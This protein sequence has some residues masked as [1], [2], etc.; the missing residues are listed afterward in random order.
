MIK[1][2]VVS[3]WSQVRLGL[4]SFAVSAAVLSGPVW[5]QSAPPESPR[6]ALVIGQVEYS[7][8]PLANYNDPD[9]ISDKLLAAGFDVEI[10]KDLEKQSIAEKLNLL[11]EKAQTFGENTTV[12]V[13]LSGRFAQIDGDNIFLP[14]GAKID[15]ATSANLNGVSIKS[16]V[17]ALKSLKVKSRVILIDGNAP[18]DTLT[19]ERTFSPGLV[20]IE[21]PEGFLISYNQRPGVPLTDVKEA[22][23]PYA[24]GLLEAIDVHTNQFSDVVQII[25]LRVTEM[26]KGAQQPFADDKLTAK[27]FSFFTPANATVS[28]DKYYVK[29]SGETD[30]TNMARDEAYKKVVSIDTI[31]SYQS[32]ITA[33][34]QDEA[35]E[36]VKFNLSARREA[37]VWAKALEL[38]TPEGYWTYIKY[39]PNG[40]NA[41]VA[42]Y[43]LDRMGEMD[44][45]PPSNFQ[46][47]VYRDIPPPVAEYE[48]LGSPSYL[49][50]RSP[51]MA[52]SLNISP[53]PVA[54]AATVAAVAAFAI[55]RN[56]GGGPRP[57]I[58]LQASRPQWAAAPA[59]NTSVT[60]APVPP[61]VSNTARPASA[62]AVNPAALAPASV[63]AARP[64]M[65]PSV[66]PVAATAAI[67]SAP[68]VSQ[69]NVTP[70]AIPTAPSSASPAGPPGV[71]ALGAP[72]AP[73]AAP[74][75][76][77]PAA[78]VTPLG[79]AP[80]A[81]RP[82]T[83][84]PVP[85]PG[86]PSP[87]A[88]PV[89]S[90]GANNAIRP[91]QSGS[92]SAGPVGGV[93][94]ISPINPA[95]P[96]GPGAGTAPITAAPQQQRIAPVGM[97]QAQPQQMQQQQ[98]FRQ[99]APA[100]QQQ[101]QRQQAA[102]AMQQRQQV[103]Q[104]PQKAA[105][106]AKVCTPP[107]RAAKQC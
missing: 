101:Q 97:P 106:A 69:S 64:A 66:A 76:G 6:I 100:M 73:T 15:T 13:Y 17:S 61:A 27:S 4:A 93:Q 7:G 48:I 95:R 38:N 85:T 74:V 46:P 57:T 45:N 53:V 32:F 96:S 40:G 80:S 68:A 58:P 98:Q 59:V 28:I 2:V 92:P 30:F 77:A 36:M 103:I 24:V 16:L 29:G 42:R 44:F 5:A 51:P 8:Y 19:K 37:E 84:G 31:Q 90:L 52:P 99:A 3:G 107:M 54:V 63:Q 56:S 70:S 35:V 22:T 23:S 82:L 14:V 41:S 18:P 75:A 71:R 34:P 102:P 62:A 9:L 87:S 21:L 49:P 12:I 25:S 26:T 86:A 89:T 88:A 11:A 20:K 78:G 55:T 65:A 81:V 79:S 50:I 94:P 67:P 83:G 43:R 47:L 10:G 39:Y 72:S 104:V 33:F 1:R 60:G 105:P 91:L